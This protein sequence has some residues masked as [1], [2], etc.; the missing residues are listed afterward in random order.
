MDNLAGDLEQ[1]RGSL[2]TAFIGAGEG[3]QGPLRS[4]CST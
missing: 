2:E 1:L 4:W 3:S